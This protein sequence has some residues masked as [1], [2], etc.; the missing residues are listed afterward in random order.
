MKNISQLIIG[1]LLA[2]F[3]SCLDATEK[4]SSRLPIL[5]AKENSVVSNDTLFFENDTIV[6]AQPIND[7]KAAILKWGL[8]GKDLNTGKDTLPYSPLGFN[9]AYKLG[10]YFVV[11]DGCGTGCK[12]LYFVSFESNQEGM[13]LSPL[14]FDLDKEVIVYQGESMEELVTVRNIASG[15]K[16]RVEEEFD[17]TKRPYSLAIDT[18]FIAR[19]KLILTWYSP[20]QKKITKEIN[21]EPIL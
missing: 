19:N 8:V 3:F 12:Y 9:R 15:K 20:T 1:L 16:L 2:T 18:A 17:K 7:E 14:I 6:I 4:D 21:L 11:E 10:H 13:F 5:T